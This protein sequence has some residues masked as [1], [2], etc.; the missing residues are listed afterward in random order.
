MSEHTLYLQDDLTSGYNLLKFQGKLQL[1]SFFFF[2]FFIC[3]FLTIPRI[4]KYIKPVKIK[5]LKSGVTPQRWLSLSQLVHCLSAREGG[6][7][8][9]CVCSTPALL[10]WE[11]TTASVCLGQAVSS[12]G[13]T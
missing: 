6:K 8:E 3:F 12:A 1:E 5:Q 11:T 7:V 4:T 10:L 9:L 2:L 13:F